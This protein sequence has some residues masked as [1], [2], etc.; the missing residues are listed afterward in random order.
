MGKIRAIRRLLYLALYTIWIV[1]SILAVTAVRGY[2][3][4][5]SMLRRR[6][7]ARHLLP[8]IGVEVTIEGAPPTLPCLIL[9]NH[10]SYLDPMM[11]LHDTHCY[12][13]S[14]AEI[15]SWPVL[16]YGAK[17]TGILFVERESM[18]SRRKTLGAIA[19]TIKNEGIPVLLYP[20]GTTHSTPQTGP[21]MR[22][23]FQLAAKEALPIV[24]VAVDY[25]SPMDYWLG[26]TPFVQHFLSC[27]SQK[28]VYAR[29]RYGQPI[30]SN[31]PQFLMDA[32]K[33][34]MDGALMDMRAGKAVTVPQ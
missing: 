10:R 4:R 15:A 12:P 3:P 8:A 19:T 23:G 11:I 9:C 34:W 29:L 28:K 5:F 25:G 1:G 30:Q 14:K 31:D 22:G 18:S 6:R 7:W 32:V 24:P 20:E 2:R 13:V 21:F 26:E 16:G 27:F 17:V 33:T